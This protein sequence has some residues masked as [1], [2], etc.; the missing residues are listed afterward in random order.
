MR[1]RLAAIRTVPEMMVYMAL[2]RLTAGAAA[3]LLKGA[4]PITKA[5]VGTAA[6]TIAN[7]ASSTGLGAANALLEKGKIDTSDIAP[8]WER[9]TQSLLFG[10]HGGIES[11]VENQMAAKA[12]NQILDGTHKGLAQLVA[13]AQDPE[14]TPQQ[15][16][17]ALAQAR[18]MRVGAVQFLTENGTP[19]TGLGERYAKI[20]SDYQDAAGR[21]QT[22]RDNGDLAGVAAEKEN[23]GRLGQDLHWASREMAY[24]VPE[25]ARRALGRVVD[26]SND[27]QGNDA[28]FAQN[29]VANF[30]HAEIGRT[31]RDAYLSPEQEARVAKVLD[32]LKVPESSRQAAQMVVDQHV[33]RAAMRDVEEVARGGQIDGAKAQRLGDLGLLHADADGRPSAVDDTKPLLSKQLQRGIDKAPAR[34]RYMQT[35]GNPGDLLNNL[36]EGGQ[37]RFAMAAAQT[38]ETPGNAPGATPAGGGASHHVEVDYE[39]KAGG[40]RAKTV[41]PVNAPDEA[42]ALAKAKAQ[43]EQSGNKVHGV[44]VVQGGERSE[45]G[46]QKSEGTAAQAPREAQ[47]EAPAKSG[48]GEAQRKATPEEVG[49]ARVATANVWRAYMEDLGKLGITAIMATDEGGPMSLHGGVLRFNAEQMAEAYRLRRDKAMTPEQVAEEVMKHELLHGAA[50]KVVSTAN[51]EEIFRSAPK[52]MARAARKIYGA[53]NWDAQSDFQRGHEI[54]RM[55]LEGKY[56]GTLTEQVYKALKNVADYLRAKAEGLGEKSVLSKAVADVDALLK[57]HQIDVSKSRTGGEDNLDMTPAEP[58][59]R[60]PAVPEAAARSDEQSSGSGGDG[61]QGEPAPGVGILPHETNPAPEAS[62]ESERPAQRT[63][64]SAP[65]GGY[66]EHPLVKAI[67]D[68]GGLM[69]RSTAIDKWGRQKYEANKG[70]W[71]DAPYFADPRHNKVYQPNGLT[72]DEMAQHLVNRGLLPD[73]GNEHDLWRELDKASKSSKRIE[74]QEREQSKEVADYEAKARKFER[75]AFQAKKGEKPINVSDLNVGD[76]VKV[77]TETM[78]VTHIDPDSYEV[79]MED[80]SKFGV[81]HVEDGKVIYGEVTKEAERLH[82]GRVGD[83]GDFKLDTQTEEGIKAEKAEQTR[84]AKIKAGLERRL[85]GDAGDLT[86][87]MFGEGETPLFNKRRDTLGAG[88]VDENG[89]HPLAKPVLSD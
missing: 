45:G 17:A 9:F 35:P 5:L 12:S 25:A 79:T 55:V 33:G 10:L 29:P 73:H 21:L 54:L 88:I 11:T 64:R 68:A 65:D 49:Q 63:R 61:V 66:T 13:T 41:I 76:E 7:E 32:A 22:A 24:S 70:L 40:E 83:E 44:R 42:G 51:A 53:K 47:N 6:A 50:V 69:S 34:F 23:L 38:P 72:P 3:P 43:A 27:A 89:L 19:P 39:P 85:T 60:T 28:L 67:L 75:A 8:S 20:Y 80:G 2:N 18:A 26:P 16:A 86:A 87:D 71:D 52:G 59:N 4:S 78:K 37:K 82:T 77:G 31:L 48:G 1:A 15:R 56:K 36:V 57:K 81:Q 84:R 58:V 46:G 14:A 30:A 62:P 74:R